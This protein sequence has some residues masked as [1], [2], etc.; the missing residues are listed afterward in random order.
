MKSTK[1]LLLIMFL[2]F[3]CKQKA[4]VDQKKDIPKIKS[5]NISIFKATGN[6]D[7]IKIGNEIKQSGFTKSK[8]KL[9]FYDSKR[10]LKK[11]IE[12]STKIDEYLYT[13]F[14]SIKKFIRENK[15]QKYVTRI[16]YNKKN[17][18]I[19]RTDL[20][21]NKEMMIITN[22]YNSDNKITLIETNYLESNSKTIIKKKYD[23]NGQLIKE[24]TQ[25]IPGEINNKLYKYNS[26]KNLV[27]IMDNFV[28]D[29]NY[30]EVKNYYNEKK[31]L[32][33]EVIKP[34]GSKKYMT[35]IQKY[36]KE[37]NL[38]EHLEL[39]ENQDT[40]RI[41]KSEYKY[42]SNHN[43]IQKINFYKD[44]ISS[45]VKREIKYEH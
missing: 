1:F 18:P 14:D 33:K 3:A 8:S 42:D 45:V 37:G 32:I 21:G 30:T 26:Q 39:N 16:E 20:M 19:K 25:R 28:N 23:S 2:C 31:T 24:V 9:Y 29:S 10:R 7:S 22:K 11:T 43:W 13:D 6:I 17:F 4:E 41:F 34:V 44:S 12:D 40:T 27:I 15:N 35:I 5:E 38:K 36:D